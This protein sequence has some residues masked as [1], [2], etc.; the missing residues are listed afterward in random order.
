MSTEN[1]KKYANLSYNEFYNTREKFRKSGT[2]SGDE[3]NLYDTPGHKYF[4]I[5]FYFWNNDID[6]V[7]STGLRSGGLLAPI[8]EILEESTSEQNNSQINEN[9]YWQYTSAYTY[10]KIN[11]ENERAE[12][13][14]QFVNLLSNISTNSPWYFHSIDGISDAL[15]RQQTMTENF[16]FEPNRKKISIKCLPDAYDDRI[17]TLLDLYKDITWSWQMKR[18]ILPANLRKF[19]MGI[20]VFESPITNIHKSASDDCAVIDEGLSNYQTSYKYIELHN[21]EF[22][23]NNART[24]LQTLNNIEGVR[25]EYTIDI[26]F[27]DCY[28]TRYNEFMMRKIGDMINIDS[29]QIKYDKNIVG[30]WIGESKEQVDNE[31][32]TE[33]YNRSNEYESTEF[34]D[35]VRKELVG[36][37]MN[38]VNSTIKRITLGNLHSMSLSKIKDQVSGALDG[39]LWSSVQAT[40]QYLTN[41]KQSQTQYVKEIGNLFKAKSAINNI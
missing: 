28:E 30:E 1:T 18:A 36:E 19:D 9:D 37:G 29:A 8:W 21:C 3:F 6:N 31:F 14:K 16:Q 12:K 5:F 39:H 20:Y 7:D 34:L 26:F 35:A 13:L 25:P 11:D 23:Y 27:D 32:I 15:D 2:K 22:D 17:G 41:Q 10:L 33:F 4:K 40:Q 38:I 24:G